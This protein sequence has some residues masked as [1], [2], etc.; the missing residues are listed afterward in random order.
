MHPCALLRYECIPYPRSEELQKT[1]VDQRKADQIEDHLLLLEHPAVITLGRTGDIAHLKANPDWLAAQGVE[2]V[3]TGRGGEITFHGPGQLVA[4]P[5]L[6]LEKGRQ[7]L[8]R[9]LRDLESVVIDLLADYGLEAARVQGKTGVWAAGKKIASI[10]VRASSWVTSHGVAL[11][12]GQDLRGFDWMTPCGL[13]DVTMTSLARE[14]RP[15]RRDELE[16]RFC[17]HF[18]RIF[19]R[20]VTWG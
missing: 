14:G 5:I 12:H 15:V 16:K 11:N 17:A 9:Y 19:D 8:H 4:Y 7:D 2:V 10:G 1:L 20:T 18:Q 3:R 6:K 13:E